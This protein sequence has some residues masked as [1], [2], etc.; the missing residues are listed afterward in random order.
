MSYSNGESDSGESDTDVRE[1]ESFNE[2]LG[3]MNW[4][5][6]MQCYICGMER[7]CC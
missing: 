2:C 3:K 7:Q 6:C 5:S 4:C 1:Q